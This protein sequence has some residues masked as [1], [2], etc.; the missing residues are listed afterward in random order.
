MTIENVIP[1]VWA[2]R[3]LTNLNND[4]IYAQC[5]N[6]DY[7]G[8][9]SDM[10]N[11]VKINSIGRITITTY[12][13]NTDLGAPEV[14][15]DAGQWLL[16]DQGKY[17]HFY[18]D[19]LDKAQQ[20]TS[21]MDAAMKEASWGLADVTDLYL[22]TVLLAGAALSVT[23]FTV[24]Y[25][26]GQT[27]PYEALIQMDVALTETNTPKGGRW[28][29]VGPWFEAML[30]TDP[31]F[32]SYGTDANRANLRG[33]PVGRAANFDIRVTNNYPTISSD[34]AVLAGYSGAATFAEQISK[35]EAYRPERR[36]GDA[37]KGLHIYGSK[38]TRPSNI[39]KFQADRGAF[40]A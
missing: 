14:L 35:T 4:H 5:F 6:T 1:A 36:F 15:Q 23:T 7:E 29:V 10:G 3:L 30:R 28:A 37:M 25:A 2:A 22:G 16:I 24:G 11:S 27:P 13:K 9:I 12:S 8:E 26:A 33:E 31:R 18:H 20:K 21:M 32:I 34:L 38:V 17:Y 19:D 40:A 39:C